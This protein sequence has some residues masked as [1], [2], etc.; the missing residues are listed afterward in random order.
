MLENMDNC[1]KVEIIQTYLHSP[2]QNQQIRLRQRGIDGHYV[3]FQTIKKD[4]TPI[5]RIEIENRLTKDE[6]LKLLM[7]ADTSKRQIRKNRYCLTYKNQYFE[8][9]VFPF[10]NDKAL[11]EIELSDENSPI[12]F[13]DF[14]KIIREVTAESEYKNSSL[15]QNLV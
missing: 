14:I 2:E 13:P 9:D 1:E 7:S 11:M 3:Y 12:I 5:K 15:A 4:I 6:Y 10:W 8:I